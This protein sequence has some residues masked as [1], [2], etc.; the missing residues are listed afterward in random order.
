MIQ[1]SISLRLEKY[2]LATKDIKSLKKNKE[3]L[4]RIRL[5]STF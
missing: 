1:L 4:Q 2:K 3:N 5:K